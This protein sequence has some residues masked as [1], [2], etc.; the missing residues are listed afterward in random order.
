[1]N[2]LSSAKFVKITSL[3]NLYVYGTILQPW[4]MYANNMGVTTYNTVAV[5]G[6]LE[7]LDTQL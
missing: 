5:E 1:M 4:K 6:Q 2:V 3:K 7:G